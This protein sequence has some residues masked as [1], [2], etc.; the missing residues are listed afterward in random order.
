[1]M[2]VSGIEMGRSG[3]RGFRDPDVTFNGKQQ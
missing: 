2:L 1:M 3:T